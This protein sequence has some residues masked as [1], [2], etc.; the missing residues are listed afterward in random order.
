[1]NNLFPDA[2]ISESLNRFFV[3]SLNK[4]QIILSLSLS[5]PMVKAKG[6]P[7][8]FDE[9]EKM[10]KEQVY[11]EYLRSEHRYQLLTA[12]VAQLGRD[13]ADGIGLSGTDFKISLE[14]ALDIGRYHYSRKDLDGFYPSDLCDYGIDS[15]MADTVFA[16]LR[17]EGFIT[18]S[19]Q[20]WEGMYDRLPSQRKKVRGRVSRLTELQQQIL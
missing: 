20:D 19:S 13:G 9:M 1:M 17:K 14:L 18:D 8:S 16:I 5:M 10:T 11:Y 12:L 3:D 4:R 6:P 7:I 2:S 15:D